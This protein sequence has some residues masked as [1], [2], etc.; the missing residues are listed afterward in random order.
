LG[1]NPDSA[2]SLLWIDYND[3]DVPT[4]WVTGRNTTCPY[5]GDGSNNRT[6]EL[7]VPTVAGAIILLVTVLTLLAKCAG[8]RQNSKRRRRRGNDGWDYEGVPA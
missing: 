3:L 8:N 5:G 6:K 4:C 2:G 7:V 1:S